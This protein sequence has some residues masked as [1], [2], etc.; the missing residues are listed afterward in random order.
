VFEKFNKEIVV[1]TEM[2]DQNFVNYIKLIS[3]NTKKLYLLHCISSYPV[4]IFSLN[5]KIIILKYPPILQQ[6]IVVLILVF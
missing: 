1:S 2:T 6:V 4:N 3:K 5:L